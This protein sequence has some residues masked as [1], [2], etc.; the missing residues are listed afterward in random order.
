[1]K[2]KNRNLIAAAGFI[3]SLSIVLVS[4]VT[5]DAAIKETEITGIEV[6]DNAIQIKADAPI[7]YKLY[8]PE[9]PFRVT[10]DIEG[11]R[12]GKFAD[13]IFPDRAGVSEIEPVQ[14]LKPATVARLNILLQSPATIT[15]EV[16]DTVLVLAINS[17]GKPGPGDAQESKITADGVAGAA[18]DETGISEAE[19]AAGGDDEDDGPDAA[20]VSHHDEVS[21]AQT[22][23]KPAC[24]G[25][26]KKQPVSFDVQDADLAAIIGILNYDMTG[27]NI[28]INP[29]D[30]RGKKITMKLLNVPWDQALDII[31]KT[32]S[33]E[34][35]VE[36]NVIRV[37]S[38]DTF[39][40]EQEATAAR[41]R[42]NIE[43]KVFLVNNA[44]VDKIKD[45]IVNAKIVA[46]ENIS[47]DPR[48][49]SIIVRDVPSSL[50]EVQKLITTLDKPTPQVLIEARMVE[51]S[52]N[53]DYELGVEWGGYWTPT[54][55]KSAFNLVGSTSAGATG[56]NGSQAVTTVPTGSGTT[57]Y[58]PTLVNLATSGSPTGAFTLGYLNP[59]RTLGLDLR[60][61]A[62][63][64]S[65]RGRI[66]SNPKVMT[67]DN[68]QAVIKQGEK[69][70][71]QANSANSGPSI[72]FIDADLSLTVTPHVGPDKSILLDIHITKDAA[73][74]AQAVNGTPSISTNEATTQVLI[75]NGATVVMGGILTSTEQ[76]NEDNVPGISKVPLLGALFKHNLKTV[77][78]D[79]LLIFIT[80]TVIEQ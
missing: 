40:K 53:Y 38:K 45:A 9:D 55:T 12:L 79:E 30:V 43:A 65:G 70:P 63:E 29:D 44:N 49:R 22:A 25:E 16:R 51:V 78:S 15:P 52:K 46:K 50:A 68:Q 48:T 80:P 27:C 75:T 32:F 37:V 62:L 5:S 71:Y 26:V 8:R 59:A 13:K 54:A 10:V 76:Q 64:S 69:I 4:S 47:T 18:D 28:V 6:L 39:S 11:A 61:S 41:E 74:F 36:G 73:D 2:A 67:V 24:Q 72:Q 21:K 57:P 58:F 17:D 31:L 66:I 14:I 33:L 23:A 42:A 1:M 34:K 56:I 77:T 60:I 3:L 7:T 19:L 20:V 35:I